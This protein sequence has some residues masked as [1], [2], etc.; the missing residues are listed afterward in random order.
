MR[1]KFYPNNQSV[2]FAFALLPVTFFA[3]QLAANMRL[4]EKPIY[5]YLRKLSVLL[6]LT[7][8]IFIFGFDMLDKVINTAIGYKLLTAIPVVHFLLVAGTTTLFSVC[9]LSL[10]KRFPVIDKIF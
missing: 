4:E 10:R 7:Q 5:I 9:L 2:D 6:F 8:R 3:I 1:N